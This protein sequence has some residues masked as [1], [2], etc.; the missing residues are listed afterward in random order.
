[1]LGCNVVTH[2]QINLRLYNLIL[3]CYTVS[4]VFLSYYVQLNNSISL[5]IHIT[6]IPLGMGDL[7]YKYFH[8]CRARRIEEAA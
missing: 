4:T 8:K 3:T 1:M 6:N 7:F 5:I 2:W